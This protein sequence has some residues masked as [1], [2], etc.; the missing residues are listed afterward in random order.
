ME[1]P[2][3]ETSR[4][5]FAGA[6]AAALVLGGGGFL[7]GRA[8]SPAEQAPV[9][10]ETAETVVPL[11]LPT[12]SG[13]LARPDLLALASLAADATAA[14]L[15]PD[16]ELVQSDGRRLEIR[17]PF[18]CAGPT[19]P[20]ANTGW[21]YDEANETLRV[22]V[23]PQRWTAEDWSLPTARADAIESIEG[24]WIA[25]PWTSSEA[26]PSR[27]PELDAASAEVEQAIADETSE[28]AEEAETAEAADERPP[29]PT[30]AIGQIYTTES[31]RSAPR[32]GEAF[33]AVVRVAEEDLDTSQ[34]FRLR[35]SG[36]LTKAGGPAPA[37]CRQASASRRPICLVTVAMDEVAIENPA[38]GETLATWTLGQRASS[39]AD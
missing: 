2:S 15:A 35:I 39:G 27:P 11:P 19:A 12:W 22:F 3:L 20:N 29:P 7:L 10:D 5:I 37:I 18:G 26:C 9:D 16:D 25:R 23:A 6:I 28:E 14:G 33:R 36:R 32:E 17:L 4:R 8:T 38:T 30:L 24:F 31:P 13:P 1:E 21:T 34:G